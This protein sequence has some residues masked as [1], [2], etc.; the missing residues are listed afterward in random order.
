V[1]VPV[2]I[3]TLRGIG[4]EKEAK[5]YEWSNALEAVPTVMRLA[6]PVSV[7]WTP[8]ELE[9][10]K[11]QSFKYTADPGQFLLVVIHKGVK[12]FGDYPLV[13]DYSEVIGAPPF[14]PAIKIVSEGSLLSL[15]GEKKISILTRNVPAIKIEAG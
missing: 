13:K 9:F 6:V 8:T 11:T 7:E 5:D 4:D 3:G 12:S 14:P 15:S 10:S 2:A 1:S